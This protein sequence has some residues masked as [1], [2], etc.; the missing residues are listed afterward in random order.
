[1]KTRQRYLWFLPTTVLACALLGGLFGGRVEATASP[2]D[3]SDVQTCLK[4][5]TS[6]YQLVEQNYAD[7]VDPDAAIFDNPETGG[8][9]IPGMLRQLDPHSLFFDPKAFSKLREDQEGRYSGVGMVIAP[10][11][12]RDGRMVVI[13]QEPMPD[14]PALKAG[15]RPGDVIIRVDG[16][17]TEGMGTPQVRDLL[18][19]PR[20]TAVHI[21]VNREVSPQPLEFEVVRH[22][23]P[24]PSVENAFEL[25]PGVGY[26]RLAE[27]SETTGDELRQA[28]S[29]LD[30][31]S[32]HGLVLDLRGNPGGLL[33]EAVE[34]SDH[35]LEKNQLIVYH[36]GRNSREERYVAATGEEGHQYPMV[37]LIDRGTASAAE[38]VT[39]ALQDH[40]RALVMGEPSFGKG[41]VQSV[42]TLSEHTGLALTT[43]HY[44]TPTGRLIQREY[45]GVSPYDYYLHYQE[46][47]TPSHPDV[48]RTDAGREVFG[49][50]GITPDVAFHE[51]PSN[52]LQV[53]LE[54][55]RQAFLGFALNYLR[56]HGGTVPR[57]FLVDDAVV[58][59]FRK[60]LASEEIPLTARDYKDNSN[61]INGNIRAQLLEV[62][63]GQAE[64]DKVKK[65][66][67]PMVQKAL[68]EMPVARELL[69]RLHRV[70]GT[71]GPGL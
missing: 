37:V 19:G 56:A 40:D 14:S 62:V 67:D 41:L 64:G 31:K 3:D 12:E 57:D 47:G 49:G 7:L 26:I 35:F 8:G 6:V 17:S 33:K 48:R 39:G 42:Y 30:A 15:L 21:T 58:A 70:A 25:R 60:Y 1:M 46:S 24:H 29:K 34:V 11:E 2:P 13:V 59:D 65:E 44:Y 45:S 63:Y 22:E 23:I 38:I 43:A 10:R 53:I 4:Q 55:R 61:F 69:A 28:L 20:G 36:A 18:K 66:Y 50:G 27:F 71:K 54:F 51:P 16:K 5:F 9:A 32:L 52:T 68:E